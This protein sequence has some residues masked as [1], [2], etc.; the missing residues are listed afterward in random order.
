MTTRNILIP[1]AIGLVIGGILYL[2]ASVIQC[3]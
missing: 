3:L 2:A 1:A